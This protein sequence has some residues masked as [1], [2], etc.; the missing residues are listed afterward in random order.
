MRQTFLL[1]VG[2]LG[3]SGCFVASES[4]G[5]T[6]AGP[7]TS[8][9]R[10]YDPPPGC[11][12]TA[13]DVDAQECRIAAQTSCARCQADCGG[14][15]IEYQSQCISACVRLCSATNQSAS[16]CDDSAKACRATSPR[17]SFCAD[18]V[19]D[20]CVPTP[21]SASK[22]PAT[23]DGRRKACT[24]A[25]V[26][27]FVDACWSST[28]TSATCQA[29][30]SSHPSCVQCAIGETGGEPLWTPKNS[31]RVWTNDGLCVATR[32]DGDCGRAIFAADSCAV[33]A[34][35]SCSERMGSCVM[36]AYSVSCAELT[37]LKDACVSKLPSD[38]Q[39]EC[40]IPADG[41]EDWMVGAKRLI[42]RSCGGK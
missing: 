24:D 26:T 33:S 34:C 42:A 19:G 7:P 23:I 6:P 1:I 29:F 15:Q 25:E 41:S 3:L 31:D 30:V 18:Q 4:E 14:L 16:R 9:P 20:T 12:R 2:L 37:A 17:N 13:C 8:N 35:L 38:V 10:H 40:V 11:K 5:T 21:S 36:S 28:T 27:E 22:L 39:A 32:G